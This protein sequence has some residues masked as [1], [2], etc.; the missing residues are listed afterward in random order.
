M[1]ERCPGDQTANRAELIALIRAL[2]S[3][4][5]GGKQLLVKTGSEY[6]MNCMYQWMRK[7]SHN[8]WKTTAGQPVKNQ[9]LLIYLSAL[10]QLRDMRGKVRLQHIREHNGDQG[11]EAADALARAGALLAAPQEDDWEA[12][13]QDVQDQIE[14]ELLAMSDVHSPA[15]PRKAM[16]KGVP[17]VLMSPSKARSQRMVS[18]VPEDEDEGLPESPGKWMEDIDEAELAKLDSSPVGLPAASTSTTMGSTRAA[19]TEGG[20]DVDDDDDDVLFADLTAEQLD[21]L[22]RLPGVDE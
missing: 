3:T 20:L 10:L 21:A 7:W 18:V 12:K 2:E 1:A 6:A 4:P 8:G 13:L 11:S 16:V 15:S 5:F 14:G 19:A 17:A 9:Q 22:D